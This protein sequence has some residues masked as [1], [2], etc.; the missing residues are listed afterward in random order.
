MNY[1]TIK[2]V[3]KEA[4]VRITD[5]LALAPQNDPF[6]VG[7]PAERDAARWFTDLW[8]RFGYTDGVHLRRVHYRLVSQ[9]M[10]VMRPNGL[11]YENTISSWGYLCNAGKW[12]R[13]LGLV[14][15][16]AFVDRR[17]PDAILCAH[18]HDEDPTP[19]YD[20][21]YDDDWDA[22][23]LPELPELPGLPDLPYP[24]DFEVS[25][26]TEVQQDYH[27]EIWAEKTT[28]NDVLLPL[29]RECDVN[30][31]TG[32]GEMSITAVVDVIGRV[33][34]AE[35][36]GR[37]LYI[38]DYDPAGLGMPISVSR[39]IEYL[40]TDLGSA[41]NFRL[42]P[43]VLTSDQVKQ[44]DLPRIPVKST[45]RRKAH[46]ERDHGRGQVELDALEALHSGELERIVREAIYQYY[47][48]DLVENARRARW[49]LR[50]KLYREEEN[51]LTGYED[52]RDALQADYDVLCEKFDQV[53]QEF[54]DLV[55]GFQKRIDEHTGDLAGIVERGR[56]L[57][58]KIQAD[59]EQV[60]VNMP[61][62][63]TPELV[64]ESN[65]TLFDS[66]R[67]YLKQLEAYKAY[68]HNLE[69]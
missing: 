1:L 23:T 54:A 68:R 67:D 53:R 46:W 26:Y 45:D 33:R 27:V 38:S 56:D 13:Y 65:G 63:P 60:D 37:I 32:L 15:Y 14:D 69:D 42:H 34:D 30:L 49:D 47:D 20:V 31:V 36:P 29:C 66:T 3:A 11:P 41:S 2:R 17:N 16:T 22:Y 44:Y 40:L 62:L 39:K 6:Y 48:P 21:Y 8:D 35:R 43:V 4:G 12:A 9:D 50:R 57:H 19:R 24:P 28:M 52:E 5:L 58:D 25:G 59:L 64:P 61:K 51:V 7:T 18:W 10:P 55:A